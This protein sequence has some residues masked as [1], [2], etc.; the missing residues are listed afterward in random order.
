MICSS[1]DEQLA[2]CQ[3]NGSV[4][5]PT[6]RPHMASTSIWSISL[7]KPS[8]AAHTCS[9]LDT[10]PAPSSQT[11]PVH[12]QASTHCRAYCGRGSTC[13]NTDHEDS[14]CPARTR[15]GI[16]RWRLPAPQN[17][18]NSQ[19]PAQRLTAGMAMAMASGMLAA[20]L[21]SL[22]LC[23][24][25]LWLFSSPVLPALAFIFLLHRHLHRP[26]VPHNSSPP[27]FVP[28]LPQSFYG[29][30]SA[31]SVPRHLLQSPTL[32][33]MLVSPSHRILFCPI[34]G[35]ADRHLT[36]LLSRLCG[37]LYPMT[38]FASR[39][40]E[41]LLMNKDVFRFT[42]VV[43]P[44][45]RLLATY[46]RGARSPGGVNG[47]AYREFMTRVRGVPLAEGQHD[48]EIISFQ[49]FLTYLARQE[50]HQIHP[51]FQ[52]QTDLCG[53]REINYT[54]IGKTELFERDVATFHTRI[55][56]KANHVFA[57]PVLHEAIQQT[58][59]TF[60]NH[61]FRSK[62]LHLYNI[63]FEILPY[64]PMQVPKP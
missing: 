28:L 5:G 35:A 21:L 8:T 38:A 9:N 12:V 51:D 2:R 29:Q 49:F 7:L 58:A 40:R 60:Q 1:A 31:L 62:A 27:M 56:A 17:T 41:R 64:S 3:P 37:P 59:P 30:P 43:H 52:S 19:Q 10:C 46:F 26:R 14:H 36:Q 23:R 24:M 61:R 57:D 6:R 20:K 22:R 25:W 53:I 4:K 48:M 63:D 42:F 39:D 18:S 54:F 55:G 33:R 15:N 11:S 50:T 34:P 32:D 13:T 47:P 44:F 16:D 45:T